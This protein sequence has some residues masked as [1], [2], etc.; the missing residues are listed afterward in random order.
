MPAPG[1]PRGRVE[2]HD[3]GLAEARAKLAQLGRQRVTVGFQGSRG[4]AKHPNA[5]TS[6]AQVAAWQEFGTPGSDDRT[7]DKTRT[8]IPSRPFVRTGLAKAA[9]EIQ[10]AIKRA[11]SGVI[12]GRH[13]VDEA[14]DLV[15]ARM[16]EAVQQAILD[17]HSWATPLADATVARK[18]HD[19]PLIESGAMYDAVSYAIR[20]GD[21]I[22]REGKP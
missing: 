12:D 3:L 1:Q 10:S 8:R 18:G 11:T 19:D 20:E 5:D 22:A 2:V 15:G 13:D 7:Y 16:V 4:S 14:Q 17:A 6:I 21:A 9:T